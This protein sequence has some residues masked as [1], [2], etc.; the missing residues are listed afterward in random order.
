[1]TRNATCPQSSRSSLHRTYCTYLPRNCS[2][3][4]G[5]LPDQSRYTVDRIQLILGRR[6]VVARILVT[7]M[8]SVTLTSHFVARPRVD[9]M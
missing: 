7:A 2:Y 9:N 1:M 3:G 4:L 5:Q 6:Q 8:S